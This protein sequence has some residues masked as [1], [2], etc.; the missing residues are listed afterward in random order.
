MPALSQRVKRH[1]CILIIALCTILIPL[2]LIEYM[3]TAR[4]CVGTAQREFIRDLYLVR[5]DSYHIW[6][7][8]TQPNIILNQSLH[9]IFEVRND[10]LI[11]FFVLSDSQFEEWKNGS[12]AV[13]ILEARHRNLGNFIFTPSTEGLYYLVL[14]NSQYNTSKS[15][16]FD[17]IWEADMALVDYSESYIWLA[18]SLIGLF[19]IMIVNFLSGNP[20]NVALKK[21]LRSSSPKKV[22]EIRGNE[23][24]EIRINHTLKIFWLFFGLTT[25]IAF[26]FVFVVNLVRNY[27][28]FQNF[29]EIVPMGIDITLRVAL[30]YF[31][32][33][34]YVSLLILLWLWLA[35]FLD[36][37]Q[38]LY[39]TK[40]KNL[41]W[42]PELTMQNYRILKSMLISPVSIASYIV[43]LVFFIAGYLLYQI[44]F[45][46]FAGGTLVISIPLSR[47]TFLSF[48]KACRSL[49]LKWRNQLRRAKPFE[50]NGVVIAIW[51]IPLLLSMLSVSFP[52]ILNILEI[53][54]INSF[55]GPRF[56]EF[57]YAELDPRENFFRAL[58][59]VTGEAVIFGSLLFLMV[60]FSTYY[61]LPQISRPLST[62]RKLRSL[63][64]PLIAASMAFV[65]SEVYI[66]WIESAIANR[67]ECALIISVIAFS[68]TYLAGKAYEEAVG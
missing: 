14:D 28:F 23:Y 51:M 16:R 68:A 33:F 37:L 1:L 67:Q 62:K 55:P 5:G 49:K 41:K 36:D 3:L 59:L 40:V 42:N 48:R 64:T 50:I 17:S 39:L 32:G 18:L 34:T 25:A 45:A 15:I 46:L 58:E 31:F 6:Y 29:P 60:T 30:Y 22:K 20:I 10:G 47:A 4:A 61:I 56:R 26:I 2:G 52:I 65:T 24:L 44:R 63:L 7:N 43:A 53:S 38:L 35:G 27:S 11:D 13:S 9:I 57:F 19:T 66:M 21:L 54:T 8:I 12:L